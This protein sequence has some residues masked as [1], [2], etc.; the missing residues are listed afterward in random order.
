M[1]LGSVTARHSSSGRH[2]NFAALNSGP[3]L[4]SAGRPSRWAL[5]HIS[6]MLYFYHVLLLFN[7]FKVIILTF[8]YIYELL[9]PISLSLS[10]ENGT[11]SFCDLEL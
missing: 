4:Y 7:V 3:Y 8:I 11:F 1:R 2:P 10:P 5:A 6:S 9:F